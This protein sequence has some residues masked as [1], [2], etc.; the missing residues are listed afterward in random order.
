M[1]KATKGKL[2]GKKLRDVQVDAINFIKS[3]N[4]RFIAINAPTGSGKSLIAMEAVEPPF[5]Y[6]CSSRHLQTQL[7]QDFN[8]C[9]VLWGKNNYKCIKLGSG[10]DNAGDCNLTVRCSDCEYEEAKTNALRNPCSILNFAYFITAC[11]YAG[12]TDKDRYKPRTVIIDEA[13]AIENVIVEFISFVFNTDTL[14]NLGIEVLPDRKTVLESFIEFVQQA[15]PSVSLRLQ[16]YHKQVVKISHLKH[17]QQHHKRIL[18]QYNTI[19][20]I[21]K[22]LS[23]LFHVINKQQLTKDRWV[24]YYSGNTIYLKPKW[25]TRDLV[26][27]FLF[28]YGKRF[29]FVSATLPA[30]EV[31]CKL[32]DIHADDM[33]YAEFPSIFNTDNRPIYFIPKWSLSHTSKVNE[34]TIRNEVSKLLQIETRKGIIHTVNYYLSS[35]LKDLSPRLFIHDSSNKQEVF[36]KFMKSKDGVFVSPSSI[37]GIDLP[38]DKARWTLFIKCPFPDLN[39]PFTSARCYAGKWGR[40]W[41]LSQCTQNI[42]QGSGRAV[43]HEKDWARVYIYDEKAKEILIKYPLLFPLW[44]REAVEFELRETMTWL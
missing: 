3:S 34:H 21:H 12:F 20:K 22:K 15:I 32:L 39:D 1:D 16:E 40:L 18:R 23:F 7:Q 41:Y 44:F 2:A 43:R 28:N 33:D 9:S 26:D 10:V 38:D 19:T 24:Y 37:R 4:K 42:V 31:L 35:T 5:F 14:T 13:D 27:M 8:F 6:L 36:Q 17:I 29:I 11:N 25:I 30:K